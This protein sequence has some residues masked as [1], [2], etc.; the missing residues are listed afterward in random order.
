MKL[1]PPSDTSSLS[2]L[3]RRIARDIK[4]HERPDG[5]WLYGGAGRP[6]KARTDALA[7][8]ALGAWRP[9]DTCTAL[10]PLYAGWAGLASY[11][12]LFPEG[13]YHLKVAMG[14]PLE[15]AEGYSKTCRMAAEEAQRAAWAAAR[16]IGP[17]LHHVDAAK[18]AM[19]TTF[20]PGAS[21]S[22]DEA[23]SLLPELA[24]ALGK[25]H[26]QD[27]ASLPTPGGKNWLLVHQNVASCLDAAAVSRPRSVQQGLLQ[28][29]RGLLHAIERSTFTSVP[30]HDDY[31]P[32]NTI[33]DGQTM[34]VLDWANLRPADPAVDLGHLAT[35]VDLPAVDLS[36]RLLLPYRGALGPQATHLAED[37][38][39][40]DR[41]QAYT[42][43]FRV[44]TQAFFDQ[45]PGTQPKADRLRHQLCGDIGA[46]S[47]GLLMELGLRPSAAIRGRE[48]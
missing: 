45:W 22:V 46:L 39:L 48:D 3:E 44:R 34:T 47:S 25:L 8:R 21:P 11:R 7:R 38:T 40:L 31:H 19:V 29:E 1:C 26:R 23:Q 9:N 2:T 10:D 36:E 28:L 32:A 30:V 17:Q 41:T 24:G 13:S 18:G 33:W 37:P 15:D 16:G 35:M 6:K 42:A 14:E 20:V 43:L 27:V 4:Q 5:A 12:V